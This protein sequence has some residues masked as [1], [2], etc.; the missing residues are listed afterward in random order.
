VVFNLIIYFSYVRFIDPIITQP[1]ELKNQSLTK[2]LY[3]KNDWKNGTADILRFSEHRLA[4][5]WV[6]EPN[7]NE[8]DPLVSYP[9]NLVEYKPKESKCQS[10]TIIL[11]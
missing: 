5:Y 4:C 9:R 1:E 3:N 2:Y 11:K 6:R 10:G 8:S 7:D